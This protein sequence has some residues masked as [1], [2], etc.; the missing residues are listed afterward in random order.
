[1]FHLDRFYFGT[2]SG[3]RW[4]WISFVGGRLVKEHV[5]CGDVYFGGCCPRGC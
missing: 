3:D 5:L 1:M 2:S 4:L